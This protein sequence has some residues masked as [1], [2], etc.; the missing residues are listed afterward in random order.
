MNNIENREPLTIAISGKSGCGNTTLSKRLSEHLGLKLINYTLRSLAEE[1]GMSFEDLW[2]MSQEDTKWDR[3]LDQRQKERLQK[4][5]VLS[6]RAWPFGF[7]P[8]QI[9]GFF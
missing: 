6:D 5:I 9:S 1:E 4:E 7:F 3:L 2:N 8:K